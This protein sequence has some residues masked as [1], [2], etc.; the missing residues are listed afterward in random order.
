MTSATS[1]RTTPSSAAT[2]PGVATPPTADAVKS[3]SSAFL[4]GHR[5]PEISTLQTQLNRVGTTPA[6]KL[7]GDFGPKTKAAVMAFQTA[8]GLAGDGKVGARTLAALEGVVA[9]AS[10]AAPAGPTD[11]LERPAPG[12]STASRALPTSTNA[13]AAT[14][15]APRRGL[16]PE[17]T[18]PAGLSSAA[19]ATISGALAGENGVP[20]KDAV[21]GLM[22]TPQYR[23][24]NT[25]AQARLLSTVT[26]PAGAD[27]RIV[28]GSA[29]AQHNTLVR[30][31]A[32]AATALLQ[33]TASTTGTAA[34]R[35]ALVDVFAAAPRGRADL[36]VLAGEH[37][38]ANRLAGKDLSGGTMLSHL[39]AMATAPLARGIDRADV[40]S[41]T[42]NE[43][44]DPTRIEQR[45][46]STCAATS[47]TLVL[48]GR[49]PAEYVR[50]IGGMASEQGAATLAGGQPLRRNDGSIS[51]ARSGR[52]VSERLLQ[53]AF[54]D[55]A[56]GSMNYNVSTDDSGEGDGGLTSAESARLNS[57]VFGQPYRSVTGGANYAPRDAGVLARSW[58]S[59]KS[60]FEFVT[61]QH[62]ASRPMATLQAR[63][64]TPTQI[65][66]RWGQEAHS[67]HA[68]VVNRIE[69]G[70]VYFQ[71]P[72][73]NAYHGQAPGSTLTPPPRRVEAGN[74]QSMTVA[75]F[76][77]RLSSVIVPDQ[78]ST[79]TTRRDG[80]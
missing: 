63:S 45:R 44:K 47:T 23:S 41:S 31:R 30:L 67:S 17:P 7:D 54:M 69:N 70:R 33:T 14:T 71:N 73:G 79:Q 62:D 40:L 65:G 80:G 10:P 64:G 11:T 8:H 18:L 78:Q 4:K 15:A 32:T 72:H 2:R 39:Q 25:A 1:T 9:A 58:A 74:I 42:M 29:A 20:A 35:A 36:R 37:G 26:E 16:R 49:S 13:T 77:A 56:N 3:G 66:M 21:S 76:S 75:D 24:L 59:L 43:V 48:V 61:F 22:A 28:G 5:G 6:L 19:Q 12:V 38:A 34:D 27:L 46:Q 50:L 55:Y 68:V 53:D 51:D 60:G 57:G 52:S